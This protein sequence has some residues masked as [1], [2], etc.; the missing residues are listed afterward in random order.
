MD[1]KMLK[2]ACRSA[3]YFYCARYII[4]MDR[5][6]GTEKAERHRNLCQFYTNLVKQK[7]YSENIDLRDELYTIIHDTTAEKLTDHLKS[8]FPSELG[9]DNKQNMFFNKFHEIAMEC[10]EEYTERKTNEIS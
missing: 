8:F 7:I 2:A 5:F 1:K 3:I 4:A 10:I 6:D 9:F